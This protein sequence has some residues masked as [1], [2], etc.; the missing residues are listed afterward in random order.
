[1]ALAIS[2]YTD[3]SVLIGEV[4]APGAGAPATQPMVV[5]V[6]AMGSRR[7]RVTNE[8]VRRGVIDAEAL[9]FTAPVSGS[10]TG[11]DSLSAVT[12]GIQTLTIGAATFATSAVGVTLTIRG[13]PNPTNNGTFTVVARPGAT[14]LSFLNPAGVANAA[15]A[16]VYSL[17]AYASVANRADRKLQNTTLYRNGVALPDSLVSFAAAQVTGSAAGPFN[18]VPTT[19]VHAAHLD[20]GVSPFPGP[21]AVPSPG[22]EATALRLTVATAADWDGGNV[23]VNAT[24][25]GGQTI[26][27]TWTQA[28][29][30]AAGATAI[31]PTTIAGAGAANPIF[32]IASIT[33]SA[34][35]AGNATT[36]TLTAQT[37]VGAFSLELDGKT[38]VTVVLKDRRALFM[39]PVGSTGTTGGVAAAVYTPGAAGVNLG[40]FRS[41]S[42]PVAPRVWFSAGYNVSGGTGVITLSGTNAA[43]AAVTDTFTPPALPV[44][45]TGAANEVA[46][47]GGTVFATITGASVNADANISAG[48]WAVGASAAAASVSG[49]LVFA[50]MDLG[51]AGE[52][53]AE[54]ASVTRAEVA[55]GINTGL[56]AATTAVMGAG[57][58]Y[59]SAYTWAARDATTG[60][61]LVSPLTPSSST[62]WT[63]DARVFAAV[64][65]NA[66]ATLFGSASLDA[67]TVLQLSSLGWVSTAT[68]TLDYVRFTSDTDT[69]ATSISG[70]TVAEILSVGSSAGGGQYEVDVSWRKGTGNVVDWGIDSA[71]ALDSAAQPAGGYAIV[72]G[73]ADSLTIEIDGRTAITADLAQASSA[74]LGFIPGLASTN[75][76]AANLATCVNAIVAA[77]AVY[78]PRYRAVASSVVVSGST[79]FRM[80]SPTEGTGGSVKVSAPTSNSAFSIVYGGTAAVSAV[81]TGTRPATGVDY[82]VTYDINRPT[83]DYDVAQRFFTRETAL[84]ALGAPSSSNPLAVGVEL[85]F[86]NGAPSVVVAQVNDTTTGAPTRTQWRNA[87]NALAQTDTVTDVVMLGATAADQRADL[88]DH[89]ETE[90][91]PVAGHYRRGWWGMAA[92][93]AA[94][95]RD[96][97]NTFVY[98]ATR[99]LQVSATSPA[100]GRMCVVAGPQQAGVQRTIT[101]EDGS[102]E[103]LTLDTTYWALAVAAKQSS[104]ASPAFTWT[105]Q[106]VTGFDTASITAPWDAGT[107]RF[108]QSQGVFVVAYDGGLLRVFDGV[109]TE[110]GGGGKASYMYP[111]CSA[112]K[113]N[114]TRKIK[115]ALEAEVIAVIPDDPDDFLLDIRLVI[116]DVIETEIAAGAIGA[117]RDPTTGRVRRGSVTTDVTARFDTS[118]PTKFYFKYAENLK[119]PALRG[120]GEYSTDNPFFAQAA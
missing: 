10:G 22:V 8:V 21:I 57:S 13:D 3:P 20:T 75:L 18:L 14:Q 101:L 17:P 108:M 106:T 16:G 68:Y 41:P 97:P 15:F 60:I 81:G 78:G 55:A 58:G 95:D 94:G 46:G 99:T 71:P 26:T 61:Q 70:A 28:A 77:S 11:S 54:L 104:F 9:T 69:I 83:T 91:G 85:A 42:T 87:L 89:V 114:I 4:P 33:K 65:A 90:N 6:V 116:L 43:G 86:D 47:A 76:T 88:K 63:S 111:S 66:T 113:D 109:T 19:T 100:R 117:F 98:T 7:K 12:N 5:G 118:D 67:S 72:A 27:A 53:Y 35:G 29:I 48:N 31:G 79:Y 120:H 80:T 45:G 110:A 52:I 1:M 103:T 102:T 23:V 51:V 64:A 39:D 73:T 49:A 74:L 92:A 25:A 56:V 38:P 34:G 24:D 44:V 105:K 59:G 84:A 119:Y 30:Q 96:T 36:V 82:Y 50:G 37:E 62:A 40:P 2:V 115:A 93:T 112:Q 107:R 32:A